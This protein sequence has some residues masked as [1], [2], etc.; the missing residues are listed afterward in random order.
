MFDPKSLKHTKA[1]VVVPP[2]NA[3][4]KLAA[5]PEAVLPQE[6]IRERAYELYEIRGRQAGQDEQDWL[7]AEQELLK[8]WA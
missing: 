5:M 4:A 3:P 8:K 6:R 1:N 2:K 7:C